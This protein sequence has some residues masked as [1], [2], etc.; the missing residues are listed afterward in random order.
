MAE[1]PE[2]IVDGATR[3]F[4][5]I[6]EPIAQV[7]SPAAI[8]KRFRAAGRNALLI[9][10]NIPTAHFDDVMRGLKALANFDGYVVTIPH[11]E[12]VMAHV[13]R[14]LPI[15]SAVGAANVA[16]R[17][18]DGSWSGEMYDGEGLV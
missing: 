8:T 14:L 17:E 7:K 16:R 3:I 6:G 12:R 1:T 18:R 11:K 15:A 5:I 13:D 9:P 2:R 10:L 4:A